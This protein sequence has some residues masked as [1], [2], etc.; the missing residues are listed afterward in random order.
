MSLTMSLFANSP[1][2]I[3]LNIGVGAPGRTGCANLG[4]EP[5]Y[6]PTKPFPSATSKIVR[7][8]YAFAV[9]MLNALTFVFMRV[10]FFYD[11]RLVYHSLNVTYFHRACPCRVPGS[12]GVM[13]P[14]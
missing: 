2:P 1:G 6:S 14:S 3:S 8:K 9:S 13:T 7:L 4:V 12:L 5:K 10:P 11:G